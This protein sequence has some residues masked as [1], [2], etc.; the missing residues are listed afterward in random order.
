MGVPGKVCK[1]LQS[2]TVTVG[3]NDKSPMKEALVSIVLVKA[4][5]LVLNFLKLLL[6][7]KLL[8]ALFL[9][10]LERAVTFEIFSKTSFGIMKQLQVIPTP[11]N[12]Y[13]FE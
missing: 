2:Y 5:V 9:I 4:N 12:M 8:L 7:F 6:T 10:S 1:C 3:A 11:S 13:T